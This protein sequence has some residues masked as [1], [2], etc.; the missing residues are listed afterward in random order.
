M[1]QRRIATLSG[2]LQAFRSKE[3][4]GYHVPHRRITDDC[5]STQPLVETCY[6]GEKAVGY[7]QLEVVGGIIVA[8]HKQTLK[9]A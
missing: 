2:G 5:T 3:N 4:Q 8:R 1:E 9:E 6:Q 7:L